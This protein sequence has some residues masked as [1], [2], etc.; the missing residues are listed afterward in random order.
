MGFKALLVKCSKCGYVANYVNANEV[1]LANAG[2]TK[3][4][5]GKNICPACVRNAKREAGTLDL[6]TDFKDFLKEVREHRD[7]WSMLL[8][9]FQDLISSFYAMANSTERLK[10]W[11]YEV[12]KDTSG[13]LEYSHIDE[14]RDI[15]SCLS[16]CISSFSDPG[17]LGK[18]S[19]A[20]ATDN[21]KFVKGFLTALSIAD[22][23]GKSELN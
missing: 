17:R 7:N 11:G 12:H 10:D 9:Q 4:E 21:A 8:A 22:K 14:I 18:L 2:W 23:L 16:N 13:N 15:M 19:I 3:D 5:N 20:D 1:D 6:E